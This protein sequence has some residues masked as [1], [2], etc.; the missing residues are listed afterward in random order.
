[1]ETVGVKEIG[2]AEER[3]E[4][5]DVAA[6]FAFYLAAAV[7][8][9]LLLRYYLTGAGGPSLLAVKMVP[10]AFIVVTLDELRQ[11]RLYPSLGK[12]LNYLIAG[13]YIGLCILVAVYMTQEYEP[14]R[15]F[16]LG[17]WNA[18]DLVVGG[19][20][21][22][23]VLEY[24]RR[25]FLTLFFVNALLALYAVYGYLVPGMFHHPGLSWRRVV[26]SM[27]VEM[28]TGV[29]SSL[30]QLA[31]TLIGSFILVLSILT[32]FGCIDSIL[33]GASRIA[34]RFP[35]L[36]PQAAVLGSFSV[37]AVSGSGAANA[38]TTGSATIPAL[39]RAGFSRVNA[40][41][42]ETAS[43]LG[44]QL[45]PPLM[46]IAAFI[47]ANYLRV[48]Y[49]EVVA[50]GFALAI[51]YFVGVSVAVYL[52]STRYRTE[53]ASAK[54]EVPEM[55]FFDRVN[56][57]AYAAAVVGL[58]YLM[59]VL[60]QPAMG[61]A[62]QVFFALL[63]VLTVI[64]LARR[65]WQF[66]RQ[67][68]YDVRELASPYTTSLKTFATMTAELTL[69]LATLGIL[70]GSFTITGVPDKVGILL[71]ELAGFHIIAMVL[72]G[73]AFGYLVGM[74]LPPAPTYI[75]TAVVIAPFMV[76]AGIEPWVVHFYAFLIAV[77][78]ELSPP[79]SVTA[80]VTSRIANASFM[81]TMFKAIELCLP[82]L[83][84]MAAIFT[85]PELVLLPGLPQLPAFGMV[86]VATV[87]I[88]FSIH[89]RYSNKRASDALA[90]LLLAFCSLGAIFHPNLELAT[91]LLVPVLGLIGY[92]FYRI[93]KEG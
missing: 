67:R 51:I 9:V 74:G 31:L 62:Q 69:L 57:L 55:G 44:G 72:V 3:A 48:S 56:I 7:F 29:F 17:F 45:M 90:R 54:L 80:A 71:M 53:L 60:R 61:S 25:R 28:T 52:L 5:A 84:L 12:P 83:I 1:V 89:G 63:V 66:Y 33:K 36:L 47:M 15:L 24:T 30:P 35:R 40:A 64:F 58:I 13:V 68:S 78:G 19:I 86:L 21:A 16:R 43:S 41:A 39:I 49:F 8:F 70:T 92:G 34:L 85:R 87:G 42:I 6:T 81:Q 59:G 79:T 22:A 4:Q 91:A 27:S 26:S 14:I 11:N 65:L 77:F 2:P 37:A 93:A 75:V 10:L 76:R 18:N 20:M 23:L 38:A 46:G 82:L 88:I 50:R 32:G 73:F